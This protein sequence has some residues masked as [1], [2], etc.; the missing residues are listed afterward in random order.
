[1]KRLMN[2]VKLDFILANR[3]FFFLIMIGVAFGYVLTVN[4]LIPENL[5]F[6]GGGKYFTDESSQK[7]PSLYIKLSGNANML[8]ESEEELLN[9]V[10]SEKGSMGIIFRD[11]GGEIIIQGYESQK[12]INNLKAALFAYQNMFMNNSAAN[13][14]IQIEYLSEISDKISF[15]RKIIPMMMATDIL[16]IAL[17]FIP[18]MVFQEKKEG[19]ITA[20]R[21]TSATPF[22]YMLSKILVGMVLSIIFSFIFIIFTMGSDVDY[23]KI[24]FYTLVSSII[25]S[26]IGLIIAQYFSSISEFMVPFFAV[27]MVFFL[28][29]LKI[30]SPSFHFT[31][32]E[33]IPSFPIMIGM[34][35]IITN[36]VTGFFND[37][38]WIL[39]IEMIFILPITHLTLKKFLVKK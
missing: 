7:K 14:D 26:C 15:N 2:T 38:F 27:S 19:S 1:M 9:T 17:M 22:Q 35:D 30:F 16:L 12:T 3:N 32:M 5:E 10:D 31:G 13:K 23:L 28:P 39:I 34:D 8:L 4:F 21:V 11:E 29:V 36:R 24:T 25:L 33:F 6:Q 20:Y 18:V 37:K